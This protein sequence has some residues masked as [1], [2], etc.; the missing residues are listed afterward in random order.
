MRRKGLMVAGIPEMFVIILSSSER[1][2]TEMRAYNGTYL[3][4][5]VPEHSV[6]GNPPRT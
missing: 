3:Y 6:A 2:K 1:K 5:L 4:F